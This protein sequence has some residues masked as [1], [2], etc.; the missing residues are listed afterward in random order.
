[1][2][3]VEGVGCHHAQLTTGQA[4]EQDTQIPG[5]FGGEIPN[6][7]QRVGTAVA[8]LGDQ[9]VPA[10]RRLVAPGCQ[11]T[12]NLG[13][14]RR[15]PS[16][17]HESLDFAQPGP[18]DVEVDLGLFDT[19]AG[20]IKLDLLDPKLEPVEGFTGNRPMSVDRDPRYQ[21]RC[22][23]GA[24]QSRAGA[25]PRAGAARGSP[26]IAGQMFAGQGFGGWELAVAELAG[27]ELAG[28]GFGKQAG[29]Q[30]RAEL[31][32][33]RHLFAGSQRGDD[34]QA[35]AVAHAHDRLPTV[36]QPVKAFRS[37]PGE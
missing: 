5:L 37:S 3:V 34:V 31:L 1:M 36:D 24:D 29:A 23:K 28:R 6:R 25:D 18:G 13:G 11:Q 26:F 33:R 35:G 9:H 30:G 8:S 17:V 16:V 2:H 19:A 14:L 22:G 7:A 15:K 10:G 20:E 4:V 12:A 32:A 21:D 27:V